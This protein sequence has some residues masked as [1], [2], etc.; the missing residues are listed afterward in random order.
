MKIFILKMAYYTYF[1]S[2]CVLVA[3][4]KKIKTNLCNDAE[5][6]INNSFPP[7]NERVTFFN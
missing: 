7:T 1:K 6:V 3:M 4:G 5:N 2:I